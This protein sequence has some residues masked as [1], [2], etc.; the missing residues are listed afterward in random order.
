MNH[1]FDIF[2]MQA[3]LCQSLGHA[4]R[5]RIVHLLK[6]GPK[7]VNEIAKV[8][9]L[10]QPSASRHLSVLRSNGVLTANRKGTEV[11]YAIANPKIVEVCEMMRAILTERQS[12]YNDILNSLND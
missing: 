4:I 8:I 2:E 6:E 3:Q 1:E 7:S 10:S 9:E 5:L 12:Q 11:F